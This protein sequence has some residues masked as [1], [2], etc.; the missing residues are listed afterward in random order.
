MISTDRRFELVGINDLYNFSQMAAL[1]QYDSV[2]GR[3]AESVRV[4]AQTMY[5]GDRPVA[6]FCEA[7]PHRL[8]LATLQTDIVLACCGMFLTQEACTPFL[9]AGA[10]RV[11]VSTPPKDDMPVFIYGIN[12]TA[13]VKE[14]I[15]SNSSC[16]ANAIVPILQT[17]DHFAPVEAATFSMYHSY[18]AYQRLLDGGHYSKD[19]RRCR[20][21]TQNIIPLESTAASAV[22]CFFPKLRTKLYA[23]SIR[24]PLAATTRYDLTFKLGRGIDRDAFE[25]Y[26]AKRIAQD[27][28]S[29]LALDAET[30]VSSD[31]IASPFSAVIDRHAL[32]LIGDDLLKIGAWQDNEYGYAARLVDMAA[33]VGGSLMK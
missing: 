5:I 3:F 10:K 12:H 23:K 22:A 9:E 16:S 32:M 18:T 1:L 15:L 21:G 26:L 8:P 7:S 28:F 27:R 6:L 31:Y 25:A 29:I 20:S 17:V 24:V 33:V 13:Y 4:E 11:I 2:Y 30:K 19:I 14:S